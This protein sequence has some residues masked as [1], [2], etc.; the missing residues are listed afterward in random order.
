MLKRLVN[1]D[2]IDLDTGNL[3]EGHDSIEAVVWFSDLVGFSSIALDIGPD[4]TADM[5]RAAM[6]AQAEIV[7]GAGGNIDKFQ[8]D[9]LMAYWPVMGQ[10]DAARKK[11]CEDAL[12]AAEEALV[13]VRALPI[14][15]SKKKLDFRVGMHLGT[16]HIVRGNFGSD[17]RYAWTLIGKDVNTAARLEQAKE[18]GLHPIR[19]SAQLRDMLDVEKQER[20]GTEVR[21]K[22]KEDWKSAFTGTAPGERN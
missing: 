8:G 19:I 4:Q 22:A 11:A 2:A 18:D 3:R 7:Q 13:A 15:G 10:G 5:I 9:G 14:P 20:Y 6:S 17:Q 16:E 21:F 12:Q 1:N